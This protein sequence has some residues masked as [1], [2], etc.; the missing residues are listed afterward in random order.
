MDD[1]GRDDV[2]L[3]V[4]QEQIVP[5]IVDAHSNVGPFEDAV[6]D[7]FEK[8]RAAHDSARKLH[9][10]DRG[11]IMNADGAGRRPAP[12]TDDQR[13]ARLRVQHH[14]EMANR[15][16]LADHRLPRAGLMIA[17]DGQRQ[18]VVAR[19][20]DDSCLDAFLAPDDALSWITLRDELI[21]WIGRR[22]YA[23]AEHQTHHKT[24]P[25]ASWP[26]PFARGEQE[27][28]G[29][30]ADRRDQDDRCP[31][32]EPGQ[33]QKAGGDGSNNRPGDVDGIER[34]DSLG[35]G[36]TE[37]G[38]AIGPQAQPDGKGGPHQERRRKDGLQA[39]DGRID[40]PLLHDVG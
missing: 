21:E 39:S 31:A 14:R 4:G 7:L 17:V 34:P 9:D 26:A 15:V 19:V 27:Q 25:D 38:F 23:G 33:E 5:A 1:I 37:T 11:S 32:A 10:V 20:H 13:R 3:A 6:I 29:R 30:E 12:E 2:V 36:T 8:S 35:H 18:F 24:D 16:M 22:P 28:S 40:Q